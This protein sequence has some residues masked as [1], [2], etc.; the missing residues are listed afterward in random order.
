MRLVQRHGRIDRI[1]SRHHHIHLRCFFPDRDLEALLRLEGRLQ[2]KLKQA[3]AAFG[4]AEVPPGVSEVDRVL[5]ETREEIERL[6]REDASLFSDTGS[7]SAS[8]EEFQ[9]RVAKALES[10]ATRRSVLDLPWGGG[11]GLQRE[12]ADHGI[13]FCARVADHPR[14]AFRYVPLDDALRTRTIDHH[15]D[16]AADLLTCLHQADPRRADVPAD[17]PSDLRDAAF[18]SWAVAQ[19]SIYQ[20]WMRRTDPATFEP[21][22]P[23]AMRDAADLVRRHGRRSGTP[24]I[25]WCGDSTKTSTYRSSGRSARSCEARAMTWPLPG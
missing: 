4:R 11:S 22:V 14:P 5:S 24:R 23:K 1:G 7:A 16:V 19:R 15:P 25:P 3:A 12:G 20:E 18:D 6:S 10:Q 9:R 17:L 8:C 2:R 21:S 13:V